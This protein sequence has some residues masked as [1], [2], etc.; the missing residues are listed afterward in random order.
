MSDRADVLDELRERGV[1]Y[2]AEDE[3]GTTSETM[4]TREGCRGLTRATDVRAVTEADDIP[5]GACLCDFCV[6]NI[7][8][9]SGRERELHAQLHSADPE[10]VCGQ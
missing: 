4:H 9:E 7:T 6:G 5:S 2:A 1:L 3:R 10:E 8:P